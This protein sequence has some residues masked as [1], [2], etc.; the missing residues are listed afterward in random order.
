MS[1]LFGRRVVV[2]FGS[3]RDA[4]R[5]YDGLRV[6]FRIEHDRSSSPSRGIVV[7][8]NLAPADVGL[9]NEPDAVVRVLAGYESNGGPRLI[10]QGAPI[11]GGVR[12][13]HRTGGRAG[14]TDRVVEVEALDGGR[15]VIAGRVSLSFGT[16]TTAAQ[17]VDA[18][19]AALGLPVGRIAL[20]ASLTLPLGL[21]L[22]GP[23]RDAL[24][25]LAR[26]LGAHW[27]VRDGAL[28]VIGETADTAESAPVYSVAGRNLIAASPTG[29]GGVE[30][31]ALLDPAMRPGRSFV[32]EGVPAA[33]RYVARDVIFEGDSGWDTPFYV[34]ITGDRRS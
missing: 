22:A 31:R 17:A 7:I 19:A 20:P 28:Y 34:T 2:Q 8:H 9:L 10:F 27:F 26:T 23:A 3:S 21:A 15:E 29:D 5:S 16:Q 12:V 18:L 25:S 33:G 1:D 24:D 32:V 14:A 4:G 30:V 11:Q 13:E 6:W